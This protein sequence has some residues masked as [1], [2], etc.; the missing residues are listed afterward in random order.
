MT[1]SLEIWILR[2]GR[3]KPS[4][5]APKEHS[6]FHTHLIPSSVLKLSF[7]SWQKCLQEDMSNGLARTFL[8]VFLENRKDML[9]ITRSLHQRGRVIQCQ[10]CF[11][12]VLCQRFHDNIIYLPQ[13][14]VG[15]QVKILVYLA[16]RQIS[17]LH[18]E[19][20]ESETVVGVLGS[21]PCKRLWVR[22][23]ALLS[24]LFPVL[25]TNLGTEQTLNTKLLN[26]IIAQ[27]F[28]CLLWARCC[29]SRHLYPRTKWAKIL[30]FRT[31]GR[32]RGN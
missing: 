15:N 18:P 24:F 3:W 13:R 25:S 11:R 5:N 4:N 21:A 16:D 12:F 1:P 31:F 22:S 6:N 30:I 23:C 2:W 32:G 20:T 9:F 10:I 27:I 29:C 28:E 19:S 7:V 14:T 17:R 8:S 26:S